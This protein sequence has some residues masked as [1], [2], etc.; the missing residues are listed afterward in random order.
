M[1]RRYAR[2]FKRLQEFLRDAEKNQV[3]GGFNMGTYFASVEQGVRGLQSVLQLDEEEDDDLAVGPGAYDCETAACALGWAPAATGRNKRQGE[4]W[5][6]YSLR[7]FGMTGDEPAWD[8]VFSCAWEHIDNTARGASERI[9]LLLEHGREPHGYL[10]DKFG[11][12]TADTEE[13]LRRLRPQ[14]QACEYDEIF[15]QLDEIP[16][17]G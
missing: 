1:K 14:F 8:W 3:P 12:A 10:I 17:V 5:E 16:I 7:V 13:R 11:F 9:R 4:C 6:N 2:E 15:R